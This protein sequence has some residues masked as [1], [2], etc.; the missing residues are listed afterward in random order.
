MVLVKR[1]VSGVRVG[2]ACHTPKPSSLVEIAREW[3]QESSEQP[4]QSGV[5]DTLTGKWYTDGD[6]NESA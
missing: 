2:R 3:A 6:R 4:P 1:V 5:Q